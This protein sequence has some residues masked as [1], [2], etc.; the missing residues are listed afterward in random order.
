MWNLHVDSVI[1]QPPKR[2]CQKRIL[3]GIQQP[4]TEEGWQHSSERTKFFSRLCTL[5]KSAIALR[6]MERLEAIRTMFTAGEISG[7][8]GVT[9]PSFLNRIKDHHWPCCTYWMLMMQLLLLS[10]SALTHYPGSLPSPP[11]FTANEYASTYLFQKQQ[12]MD[13]GWRRFV[14]SLVDDLTLCLRR[15][16]RRE[17]FV[18][19]TKPVDGSRIKSDPR[20]ALSVLFYP[21][22]K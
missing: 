19:S 9:W 7:L 8:I 15:C 22:A 16:R 3:S 6:K 2:R 14:I 10:L 20:N 13:A 18:T 12:W 4:W 21:L 17:A 1:V 11:K 5:K